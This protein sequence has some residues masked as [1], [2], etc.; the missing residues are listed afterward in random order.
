M[1]RLDPLGR[2]IEVVNADANYGEIDPRYGCACSGSQQASAR[3]GN[4]LGIVFVSVHM[5]M[6]IW[7]PTTVSVTTNSEEMYGGSMVT[8]IPR[9]LKNMKNKNVKREIRLDNG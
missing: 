2:T 7:L 5:D 6:K 8:C 1:K 3:A 9:I 4:I